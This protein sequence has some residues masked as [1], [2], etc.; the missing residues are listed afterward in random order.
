MCRLPGPCRSECVPGVA[1][2]VIFVQRLLR[3]DGGQCVTVLVMTDSG[4]MSAQ[5]PVRDLPFVAFRSTWQLVFA[6]DSAATLSDRASNRSGSLRPGVVRRGTGCSQPIG[7]AMRSPTGGGLD[8]GRQV[9]SFDCIRLCRDVR[10]RPASL[11]DCHRRM[12]APFG[13]ST[14]L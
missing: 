7:E 2:S 11:L 13:C 8:R 12:I 5:H 3:H 4:S 6:S 10:M 1:Q 14:R 9:S